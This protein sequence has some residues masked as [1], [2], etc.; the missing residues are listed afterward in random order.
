MIYHTL[1]LE[2][3]ELVW[4]RHQWVKNNQKGLWQFK[5]LRNNHSTLFLFFKGSV[6]YYCIIITQNG[7]AMF[8][9][10]NVM[11]WYYYLWQRIKLPLQGL[12]IS[13]WH[14]IIST[15]IIFKSLSINRRHHL[16][17]GLHIV[18]TRIHKTL[19]LWLLEIFVIN[20]FNSY[21]LCILELRVR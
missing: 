21:S 3:L 5:K 9:T 1:N 18:S 19:K 13:S 10:D 8:L 15:M 20:T 16:K 17:N 14:L 7:W 2:K 4:R 6:L 12:I 11:E